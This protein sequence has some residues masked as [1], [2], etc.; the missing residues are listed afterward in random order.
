M[1]HRSALNNIEETVLTFQTWNMPW[2]FESYISNQL[3]NENALMLFKNIWKIAADYKNWSKYDLC[4]GE[5]IT[6]N[7][8]KERFDLTENACK[9]II[10][11]VTYEW[12]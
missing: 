12:R 1:D 4:T 11:A 8:L 10:K 9:R 3:Q 5:M 2:K 6:L 7:L